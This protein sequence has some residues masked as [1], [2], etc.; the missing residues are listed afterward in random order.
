[1][2]SKCG[3]ISSDFPPGGGNATNIAEGHYIYMQDL[4]ALEAT[5]TGQGP[6]CFIPATALSITPWQ[7]AL[8]GHQFIDYILSG[9]IRGFHLVADRSGFSLKKCHGNLPLVQQHSA[10]VE[11]HM[12][13]EKATNRVLGPLPFHLAKRCH[14][15]PIGLI[16]KP[17][18]PGKWRVIVSHLHMAVASMMPFQLITV[19]CIMQRCLMQQR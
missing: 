16:S 15:S 8:A 3:L 6:Q 7:E 14:A 5:A 17:H 9:L 12:A 4:H 18:Q 13:R 2:L 10:I 19:T 11:E 1:M